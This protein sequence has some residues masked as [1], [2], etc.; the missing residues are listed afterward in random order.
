MKKISILGSTGSIGTQTLEVV[1]KNLDDFKVIGLTC[2]SNIELIRNQIEEFKPEIVCIMDENKAKDLKESSLYNNIKIVSGLEGLIEVSTNLENDIL[3]TA[4]VGSIGLLPTYEAVKLGIDIA[5]ANKETLVTAGQIIMEEARKSGSKILPVDSEHSAIFQCI[6]GNKNKEIEKIILTASGGAF[7]DK[8]IDELKKVKPKDA[9]KHPNWD[10]GKKITIDSATMMNKG[11]EVIEAKWLFNMSSEDIDVLIH[12]ESII[13]SMVQ[14]IDSSVI[15]QM[16]L[17]DMKLPIIFALN[18]PER[19]KTDYKRLDLAK[20]GNLSFL[21]PDLI[22][23]KALEL[24]YKAIKVGGTLPVVLNTAN[25]I[26]VE[27][28][29]NNEIGFLDI[30][31]LVEKAMENHNVIKQPSIEDIIDIEKKLR[32]KLS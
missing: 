8:E 29:L 4:V 15:S 23:Y 7:L 5:L 6:M 10:M 3:L 14:F 21:K 24:A 28:F 2:N 30:A 17:P 20:I 16:G 25:E 12:R 27:K 11:L 19:K 32:E 31:K 9:L 22:K 1:R 13:H 18:Y 26:Y